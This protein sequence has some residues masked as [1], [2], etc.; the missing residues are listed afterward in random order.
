MS[1]TRRLPLFPLRTVLF[2]GM[3]LPLHVLEERHRRMIDDCLAAGGELGVVF[4]AR[5]EGTPPEPHE[6]GTVARVTHVE[7]PDAERMDIITVGQQRFR[8]LTLHHDRPYLVG[9][10]EFAP[11]SGG[12]TV[13]AERLAAQVRPRIGRYIELLAQV[14]GIDISVTDVPE[15]PVRL[16]YM[17]AIA[18]QLPEE[19]KQELLAT[20]DVRMLLTLEGRI[21]GRE[22]ALLRFAARTQKA[23]DR[24][25][26]GAT[27]YLYRN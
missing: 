5:G 18:L 3:V 23:Q 12:D 9:E 27:H 11:L 19:D 1:W 15:D 26:T 16:A 25:V 2:P 14:V 20:P 13:E 22:E 4:T 8:I 21:L 6:I 24:L 7:R 17:T 10:V